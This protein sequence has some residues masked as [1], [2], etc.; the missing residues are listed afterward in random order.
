MNPS[1][2][3]PLLPDVG[4]VALVPDTWG[5]QWQSRHHVLSRLA[6]YYQVVWM[7]PAL[8]WRQALR[9]SSSDQSSL[10]E[11][12]SSFF[13]YDH[14]RWLPKFYRPSWLA[15]WTERLRFKRAAAVLRRAG[16][17]KIVAYVW[18]P[19]F[20]E[21]LDAG[22]F[23][24]SCYHIDD[25]YSFS[26]DEQPI[27]DNELRL[28]RHAGQVFIHS[29]AMM[30]HKGRFNPR[31][32]HVPNGVDFAAFARP[33]PEPRDLVTIPHPRVGYS[34]WLKRQLDW[35]LLLRIARSRPEWHFIFVGGVS[36]QRELSHAIEKMKSLPNAYFL[37]G[38]T[39]RE[40]AAYPQHFDICILPYRSDNYTKYIYPLKMHE[41]LAGGRP[42]VS[43]RLPAVEALGAC[44]GMAETPEEWEGAISNALRP[45]ANTA[46]SKLVRQGIAKAHDW[47]V[48]VLRIATAMAERL[49]ASYADRL[50]RVA[51]ALERRADSLV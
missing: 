32:L 46:E 51:G 25:E 33:A 18:R 3:H 26:S 50:A 9:R 42:I 47:E 49:G 14:E 8:E 7:N 38:K 27:P 28:L 31:T 12:L 34:G 13:V 23:D 15:R 1:S 30:N 2:R 43:T 4:V 17:K 44:D 16:C 41:Y 39:T 5:L 21:A 20:A 36:H 48:L 40:M 24:L 11:S 19:E 10:P 6:R 35:D 22:G 45:E 29:P 37:G